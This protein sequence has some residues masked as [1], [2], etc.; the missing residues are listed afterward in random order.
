MIKMTEKETIQELYKLNREL[1]KGF[2][3]LLKQ[4]EQLSTALGK[5]VMISWKKIKK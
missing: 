3:I 5:A 2:K 1:L 4:R